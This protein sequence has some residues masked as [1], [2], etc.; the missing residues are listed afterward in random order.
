[1]LDW[2]TLHLAKAQQLR[3]SLLLN[4]TL[5]FPLELSDKPTKTVLVA[6]STA[7]APRGEAAGRPTRFSSLHLHFTVS[8][9]L[10]EAIPGTGKPLLLREATP[11][12]AG[13]S[14]SSRSSTGFHDRGDGRDAASDGGSSAGDGG[15]QSD[16]GAAVA[17]PTAA[18][19]A[20]RPVS[21]DMRHGTDFKLVLKS[22]GG[23]SST[24]SSTA[25]LGQFPFVRLR[26]VKASE[27]RP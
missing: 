22:D 3:M 13:D 18:A 9:V 21:Q 1:M 2:D 6:A 19:A 11:S 15:E 8:G 16:D 4:D 23:A 12:A 26:T 7:S 20:L 5:S 27:S 10:A 17:E 24:P 25:Y 14:G